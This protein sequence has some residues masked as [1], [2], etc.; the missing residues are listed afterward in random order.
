[1]VLCNLIVV[2]VNVP[3]KNQGNN[4]AENFTVEFHDNNA[5]FHTELMSLSADQRKVQIQIDP[6]WQGS[7]PPQRRVQRVDQC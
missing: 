4:S 2:W 3:S 6:S 1:M 7:S 5:A